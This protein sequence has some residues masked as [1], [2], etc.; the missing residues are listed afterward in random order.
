MRTRVRSPP[1]PPPNKGCLRA[2]FFVVDSAG[3]R[4]RSGF[5]KWQ[6][7]HFGRTK[8]AR[9]ARNRDVPSQSP[10]PPNNRTFLRAAFFVVDSAG[11]RPRSGFTWWQDS[12]YGRTKC[13]RR[14]RNRDVPS[15]SPLPPNNRT[16]LRAAFFVVDSAGSRPRNTPPFL[17]ALSL[18]LRDQKWLITRLFGRKWFT[19]WQDSHF[20]RTKCAR[21]ARNKDVPSQSPPPPTMH[22]STS[23]FRV[24]TAIPVRGP[25]DYGFDRNLDGL[26]QSR[27]CA[28]AFG[29]RRLVKKTC[30]D[31]DRRDPQPADG[32]VHL[33]YAEISVCRF[34]P[35]C[36]S[37]RSSTDLSQECE[38]AEP[39]G[40]KYLQRIY[41]RPRIRRFHSAEQ[42]TDLPF[43]NFVIR[44]QSKAIVYLLCSK[45][46][47]LY[48][49]SA[50]IVSPASTVT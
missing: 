47:S 45:T 9:R 39:G 1:P 5:T 32:A 29:S 42:L 30:L 44:C 50:V 22:S 12:H 17:M 13:A 24:A 23:C 34:Y 26:A 15:Q 48:S 35:A 49:T 14:A 2:A 27:S 33:S 21:R 7:S 28:F 46:P 8:C 37:Y 20:G 19:K 16:S 36:R 41:S 40:H 38:V 31:L 11:S 4:P 10:L 18:N 6:D 25:T 3:S 43:F